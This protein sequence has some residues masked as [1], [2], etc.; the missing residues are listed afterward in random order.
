MKLYP[1]YIEGTIP[2]FYESDEGTAVITVPFSINRAVNMNQV[3]GFH[4]KIKTVQSNSF[5]L[6]LDTEEF[7]FDNS[8]TATFRLNNQ[9][10]YNYE[11]VA[12]MTESNYNNYI[13]NYSKT[14]TRLA[15]KSDSGK[16]IEVNKED[17][18]LENT[19]Y[20]T[21]KRRFNI[22]QFY[23]VQLAFVDDFQEIGYY[24][25][26]ATVKFTTKPTV[27]VEGLKIGAVNLHRRTYIGHYSQSS[28]LDEAAL[29]N[30]REELSRQ[31]LNLYTNYT[32]NNDMTL[33]DYEANKNRLISQYQVKS[34]KIPTQYR[35]TTEKEYSYQFILYDED[36]NVLRDTGVLLHN[37]STDLNN[38][39]SFDSFT[40]PLELAE[41]ISYYLQYIIITNNNLTIKSPKYR[42]MYA[43]SVN[44]EIKAKVITKLN[45]NNGYI[46]IHLEGEKSEGIETNTTGSFMI[47][48]SDDKSNFT[49]WDE[50][51][52]FNLVGQTPSSWSWKDMT[53]EH[54]VK[55]RYALQQYNKNDLY[56]E[57]ILS[58]YIDDDG[59]E[60]AE[61][62]E[63]YFEDAFLYDGKVQLKIK[64]NPRISSFKTDLMETK[65]DTIGSKYP[66]IFRNGAVEYK[67]FPIS[68]LISYLSDEEN[69]FISDENLDLTKNFT[70]WNRTV[71][72]DTKLA[73][74]DEEFFFD[75]ENY[76]DISYDA[77]QTMRDGWESQKA[78][79]K[80]IEEAKQRTTD[81]L[82]YNIAA[83]RAFKISVLD[84]LNNGK[85][86]LFRSP[87][88]GNYI[89][90]L[91]NVSLSP[92]DRLGRMLHTFSCTAYEIADCTY[93][94][95][96]SYNL[97]S[98]VLGLGRTYK[99]ETIPLIKSNNNN[100][101]TRY[102]Q[103]TD[104][105][106]Y[107]IIDEILPRH[108]EVVG[109]RFEN[110]P[111]EYS[112]D[113]NFVADNIW[114]NEEPFLIKGN[115]PSFPIEM[116][117]D[118]S[119]VKIDIGLRNYLI[120][121]S[122]ILQTIPQVTIEYY[123]VVDSLFNTVTNIVLDTV[124][125]S[126]WLGD[127]EH[128]TTKYLNEDEINELVN[129]G[130]KV[131]TV[132]ED[133]DGDLNYYRK[134]SYQSDNFLDILNSNK[135]SVVRF[136]Y[137]RFYKREILDEETDNPYDITWEYAKV[138]QVNNLNI[139]RY[140]TNRYTGE[141]IDLHANN[142]NNTSLR[143]DYLYKFILPKGRKIVAPSYT[144]KNSSAGTAAMRGTFS[145]DLI[146]YYDVGRPFI[147]YYDK[148]YFEPN[149][150][151]YSVNPQ[152]QE[153][154]AAD[155]KIIEDFNNTPGI[156]KLKPYDATFSINNGHDISVT[157]QDNEGN[158]I[159]SRFRS[160]PFMADSIRLGCGVGLDYCAEIQT[161]SY[162]IED[163]STELQGYRGKYNDYYLDYY[164]CLNKINKNYSLDLDNDYTETQMTEIVADF[165]EAY[166]K[167]GTIFDYTLA[168]GKDYTQAGQYTEAGSRRIYI[169][170]DDYTIVD[171]ST[172]KERAF[173]QIDRELA[174][175]KE[176]TI[177]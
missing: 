167:L 49:I 54:G 126:Q 149:K 129:N 139:N 63:A 47:S 30:L 145:K 5:V 62:L 168:S 101:D 103:F 92:E 98:T 38:Y 58:V 64:Y 48:R 102:R 77:V 159:D 79:L 43:K 127:T 163:N 83:E 28:V 89:V 132:E 144:G 46:D 72:F 12:N 130:N 86:K 134:V 177:Y 148:Y 84:W 24:S 115:N 68:G 105:G 36:G 60:I 140:I 18:Y 16:Y 55:Y 116:G 171:L 42:L 37:N 158:V 170:E 66:F 111:F 21:K 23:K 52:K 166:E 117:L 108:K 71:T 161:L 31:L 143:K 125:A 150:S 173:L 4:M 6:D 160:R 75:L 45:Y 40:L 82:D 136:L 147:I 164:D 59:N 51:T 119:S 109:L 172:L 169:P 81:L 96:M 112:K 67:E 69:L 141:K 123:E 35:D 44:P 151:Q 34:N 175:W 133:P 85:I 2:A 104:N 162:Y 94:N 29:Y 78:R 153:I 110:I 142:A 61:P 3:T 95:L 99:T 15:T 7:N 120:Q 11:K 65:I 146:L 8:S 19:E 107:I 17:S 1:P 174:K 76:S 27:T 121:S 50:I 88:E 56:S 87:A 131:L 113:N 80:E 53:I 154:S 20:Y 57:K 33:D 74:A 93:E 118:F 156:T 114:I 39:E 14:T 157:T 124:P 25:T 135:Q 13:N 155:L 90:R 32:A 41:G 9:T 106:L 91:M 22:G 10:F 165:D 122:T 70:N 152:K 128:I 176:E 138:G 97:V 100:Y 73:N 26:V 137:A